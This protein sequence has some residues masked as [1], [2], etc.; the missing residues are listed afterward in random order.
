MPQLMTE[1]NAEPPIPHPVPGA[2][3]LLHGLKIAGLLD[4]PAWQEAFTAIPRHHFLPYLYSAAGDTWRRFDPAS[5]GDDWYRLTY[6]DVTW[7]VRLTG[8]HSN[9]G[10][11]ASSSIQPS[12]AAR[13]LHELLVTDN[14][15]ILE[16]GTG[17]GYLTALLC[18]RADP[19]NITSIDIDPELIDIADTLLAELGYKP[20][21]ATADGIR[22]YPRN[23]PYDRILCTAA[24][25][26]IPQ[27]WITQTR[28][29]GRIVTPLRSAIA[30]ID[31]HDN[32]HATGRFLPIPAK[33][34]P[35]RTKAQE[36][37]IQPTPDPS[38]DLLTRTP[39]LPARVLYDDS[40]RFLLDLTVPGIEYDDQ[41]LLGAITT[42]H[43]D[44]STVQIGPNGRTQQHGPRRL[45]DEIA[46]IHEIWQRTGRPSP[47]R[48]G[49]TIERHD[50]TVYL[51]DPQGSYQWPL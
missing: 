18:H 24:V 23:A 28:P 44:G 42:R 20:T 27:A 38:T 34:L 47:D 30:V 13:M 49:L 39:S 31:V 37:P 43:P 14:K 15:Q 46:S 50:Q 12:L 25:D 35:L 40:F 19:A 9:T 33:I 29:G 21:L 32:D 48:Y 11:P 22:G 10:Q 2:N 51:D 4:D 7:V 45:C 8:P 6:R 26:L 36:P 41:G 16:I 5:V 3:E 17:T 1:P